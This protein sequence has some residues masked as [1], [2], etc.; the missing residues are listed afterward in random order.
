MDR[1]NESERMMRK[2]LSKAIIE[3]KK[4]KEKIRKKKRKK[5]TNVKA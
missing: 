5:K 3:M 4:R 2:L 1:K